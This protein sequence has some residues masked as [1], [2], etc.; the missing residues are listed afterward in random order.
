MR[1]NP[2]GALGMGGKLSIFKYYFLEIKIKKITHKAPAAGSI[3]CI[4][5]SP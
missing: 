1:M 5:D 2:S 4:S 3:P